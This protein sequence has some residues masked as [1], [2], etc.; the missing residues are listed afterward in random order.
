[1]NSDFHKIPHAIGL[2]KA[3]QRNMIENIFIAL[4]VVVVLLISVLSSSWMN[5]AI[6]MF[7]HEGSI[8]VVILNAMRLLKYKRK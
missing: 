2:A 3:T 6:G 5:M 7:V 1:M 8:L 4:L